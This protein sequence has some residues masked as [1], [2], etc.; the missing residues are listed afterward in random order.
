MNGQANKTIEVYENELL[1]NKTID[2]DAITATCVLNACSHC[3]RLN[4]GKHI[5]NEA[6]RLNL[7]D[8]SNVRLATAVSFSLNGNPIE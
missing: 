6:I 2:L 5:H 7:L 3:H 8:S 4:I 1:N